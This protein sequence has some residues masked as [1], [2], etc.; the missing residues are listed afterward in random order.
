MFAQFDKDIVYKVVITITNNTIP[1][2]ISFCFFQG[3]IY[4][5]REKRLKKARRKF[6]SNNKY[7]SFN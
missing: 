6:S 3:E 2:K 5:T 4:K 1:S 7:V